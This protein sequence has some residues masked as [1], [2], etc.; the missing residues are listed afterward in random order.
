VVF[1]LLVVGI[2]VVTV[3]SV[4]II[5]VVVVMIVVVMVGVMA[6]VVAVVGGRTAMVG[7]TATGAVLEASLSTSHPH[8]G[9]AAARRRY[10]EGLH[11]VEGEEV[12]QW[13]GG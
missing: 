6:I 5:L 4:T 7:T 1:G 8:R 2:A 13:K 11:W 12:G 10:R 9:E 3:G